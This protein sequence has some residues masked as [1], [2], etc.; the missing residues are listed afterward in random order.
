MVYELCAEL[1]EKV[2]PKEQACDVMGKGL[3]NSAKTL[4]SCS[5][6]LV[7]SFE[8]SPGGKGEPVNVTCLHRLL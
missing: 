3:W 7:E 5:R 4:P 1:N 2:K 6:E 8:L